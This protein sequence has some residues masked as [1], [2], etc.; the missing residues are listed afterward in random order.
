MDKS[1]MRGIQSFRDKFRPRQSSSLVCSQKTAKKWTN[2]SNALATGEEVEAGSVN[3]GLITRS[4]FENQMY[5]TASF[6]GSLLFQHFKSRSPSQGRD[7]DPSVMTHS[8]FVDNMT[9]VLALNSDTQQADFYFRVFSK[10]ADTLNE[11]EMLLL[12][13]TTVKIAC[14]ATGLSQLI[15][16][17]DQQVLHSLIR[18]L[19]VKG[20]SKI[21]VSR[22]Q[23]WSWENELHLLRGLHHYVVQSLV[24][25]SG[26]PNDRALSQLEDEALPVLDEQDRYLQLSCVAL[27]WF[28]SCALPS[29]YM[30]KKEAEMTMDDLACSYSVRS[31]SRPPSSPHFPTSSSFSTMSPHQFIQQLVSASNLTTWTLLY[32]SDKHGHAF[33]RLMH[34]TFHYSGPT[35]SIFVFESGLSYC[36][37]VDIE[38]RESPNR[39]GGSDSVLLQLK[40]HFKRLDSGSNLAYLNANAR[41]WYKGIL[42]GRDAERP[43][44]KIDSDFSTC[45]IWPETPDKLLCAEVWGCAGSAPKMAQVD[46]IKWENKA[47]E[48]LQKITRPGKSQYSTD[49]FLVDLVKNNRYELS[50]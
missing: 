50:S 8:V 41:G 49:K 22:F 5:P 25:C 20:S 21:E 32:N 1:W 36:L 10:G 24:A 38:W 33:N 14:S 7:K 44:I 17:A 18:S 43:L 6:L 27:L 12:L 28:L 31:L 26:Q 30:K 15:T 13:V 40:P 19:D 42:L 23:R 45:E 39:W 9:T 3:D 11:D 34:H 48:K 29:C 16:D 47:A 2:L 46:Q 4:A 37:A 35:V